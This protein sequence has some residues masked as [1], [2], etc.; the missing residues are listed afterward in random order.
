MPAPVLVWITVAI[1]SLLIGTTIALK[2]DKIVTALKGKRLA[3]LGARNVGKT[4]LIKF[5]TTGSIP[6]EYRQTSKKEPTSARRF[7]LEDLDLK[8]KESFDIPGS[9]DAYIQW[10]ELH[11]QADLIFYLLRA[12]RLIAGDVI[13][14]GR[15]RED[16]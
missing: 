11:D 4:C 7:K 16:L 8:I 10:K 14:E 13:V 3:V 5:L 12:D 9:K 1:F 2:W 15:V 6:S